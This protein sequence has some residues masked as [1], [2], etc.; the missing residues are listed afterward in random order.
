MSDPSKFKITPIKYAVHWETENPIY[1][2]RVIHVSLEDEAGGPFFVLKSLDEADKEL[3]IDQ[4]EMKVV[5]DAAQ[6]LL[7]AYPDK[8]KGDGKNAGGEG[9]EV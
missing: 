4:D 8:Y 7:S 6:Q 3:R 2:E 5:F 9:R 1:G